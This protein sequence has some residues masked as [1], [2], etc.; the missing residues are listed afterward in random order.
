[1]R[2]ISEGVRAIVT[3]SE[4]LH[5]LRTEGVA[6]RQD[7]Q[8]LAE[9]VYRIAGRLDGIDQR[10]SNIDKQVELAVKLAVRD[11]LD[12]RSEPAQRG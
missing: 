3:V 8:R 1:L 6:L 12:K 9:V 4:K 2:S 7:L 11:E 5:D 10:F